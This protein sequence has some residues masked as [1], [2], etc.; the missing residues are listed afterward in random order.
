[1][2][3]APSSPHQ[4]LLIRANDWEG[5]YSS[6]AAGLDKVFPRML[7]AVLKNQVSPFSTFL[8]W[9]CRKERFLTTEKYIL[10]SSMSLRKAAND[11]RPVALTSHIMKTFEWLILNLFRPQI[12]S[13]SPAGRRMV[14]T[15]LSHTCFIRPTPT[16]TKEKVLWESN[17]LIWPVLKVMLPGDHNISG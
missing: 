13:G 7:R 6:K 16:K 12:C 4:E 1:M 2:H 15:M 10:F 17:S 9:V 8:T 11:F 14:L 3:H 5:H